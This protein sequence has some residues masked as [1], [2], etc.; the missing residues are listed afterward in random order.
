MQELF[1]N[2]HIY[3]AVPPLYRVKVGNQELY[4]EKEAQ[5]E[6]LLVRE[7]VKDMEVAAREGE[8]FRMT[9]SRWAR[10]TR[11]LTTFEGWTA[12]FS[13]ELREFPAA[14]R[15]VIDHRLIELPV[16]STKEML[17]ALPGMSKNG[18]EF[19]SVKPLVEGTFRIKVI[20]RSTSA[21][22]LVDV[23]AD[24]FELGSYQR[25]R[26]AYEKVVEDVGLPPFTITV[27]KK[28]RA[29]ATFEELRTALLDLAKE[30]IQVSRFKGLGE[31]NPSELW[32]TTMDPARRTLMR[33]DVEDGPMASRIFSTLMGDQVEPRRQ[34]I[35]QNARD[36][37]FLDV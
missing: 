11:D 4:V 25:L 8:S 27:G 36:V 10:F 12:K 33:V 13:S 17:A 18:F 21:A 9:E 3:I 16:E 23:P 26:R 6:E 14:S 5:F 7:R 31:M 15:F 34:F 24:I 1:D 2:G 29:A 30:G 37:R 19:E 20:E 28:T 32:E 22:H 35:E